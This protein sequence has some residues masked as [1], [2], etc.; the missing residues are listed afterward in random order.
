[1]KALR[2][3]VLMTTVATISFGA[4]AFAQQEVDPDHFD[5]AFVA[6]AAQPAPKASAHAK[7]HRHSQVATKHSKQHRSHA[8]A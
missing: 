5:Q 7:S 4:Q 1:M 8:T 2:M 6:R 3:M